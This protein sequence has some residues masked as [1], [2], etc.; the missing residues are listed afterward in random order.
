MRMFVAGEWWITDEHPDCVGE[1]V[2]VDEYGQGTGYF[3]EDL[4]G[5]DV[6]DLHEAIVAQG[7]TVEAERVFNRWAAGFYSIEGAEVYVLPG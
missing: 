1:M 5:W 7:V 4:H 6:S 3:P 2:L